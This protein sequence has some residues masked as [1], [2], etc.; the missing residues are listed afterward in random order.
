MKRERESR[1][2]DCVRTTWRK[3]VQWH[4][5]NTHTVPSSIWSSE[6]ICSRTCHSSPVPIRCYRE[7]K[8]V[9]LGPFKPIKSQIGK[10]KKRKNGRTDVTSFPV[11]LRFQCNQDYSR[12]SY[13]FQYN[14]G[15]SRSRHPQGIAD[16]TN[17]PGGLQTKSRVSWPTTYKCSHRGHGRVLIL[18]PPTVLVRKSP[19]CSIPTLWVWPGYG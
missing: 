9:R 8:Q 17:L 16:V 6:W 10:R 2:N 18:A 11:M 7:L 3:D 4:P 19:T 12:I 1:C 13:V 14:Y 5:Y 15:V